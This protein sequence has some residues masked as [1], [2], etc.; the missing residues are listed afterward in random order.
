FE[1]R[2]VPTQLLHLAN[3]S[4]Y[5]VYTNVDPNTNAL[6]HIFMAHPDSVSIFW[7][8]YWFVGIDLT[9]KTNRYKMPLVEMIGMTPC[10]NN[11]LIAYA[12]MKDEKEASYDWVLDKLRLLIGY[13]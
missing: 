7:T 5:I 9:Y 4:N 12:L 6:T 10:N 2:D 8:Y 1:G 3:S 13:T 11:F